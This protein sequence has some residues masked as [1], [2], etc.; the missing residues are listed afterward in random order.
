MELDNFKKLLQTGDNSNLKLALQ[1]AKNNSTAFNHMKELLE[2]SLKS[3]QT[4]DL[5]EEI[6]DKIY[7]ED[8]EYS[9]LVDYIKSKREE[10]NLTIEQVSDKSGIYRERIIEGEQENIEFSYKE[11]NKILKVFGLTIIDFENNIK[12]K[13]TMLISLAVG[14]LKEV[15][16]PES[17]VK[18]RLDKVFPTSQKND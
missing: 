13:K 7:N 2:E 9:L 3:N 8:F 17:K 5:N 6:I 14:L 10:N 16:P 1:L 4:I 18:R 11:V 12:D 15:L